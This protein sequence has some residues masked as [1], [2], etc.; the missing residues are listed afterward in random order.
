MIYYPAIPFFIGD[1]K[2]QGRIACIR[3][4]YKTKR[5]CRICKCETSEL[6]NYYTCALNQLRTLTEIEEACRS[7]LKKD[8]LKNMSV[9]EDIENVS[10]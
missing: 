10:K 5:Q 6:N 8:L 9:A 3:S 4:G 2:E 1:N 7:N